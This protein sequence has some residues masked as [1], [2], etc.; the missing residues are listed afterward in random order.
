MEFQTAF[1]PD[2]IARSAFLA[3]GTTVLGDVTVGEQSSI[4]FGSVVR[5]DTEAIRIGAGSNIQDL[6]VLH[7]DPGFPCTIGDG[8]TVGH[9]AIVHGATVEND[10]LIGMRAVV[11]NGAVIG[12]GSLIAAG[13][14]VT[15]GM[16]IP[17]GSIVAGLPAKV[18]G[19]VREKHRSM[20]EHAA[21][22]Y[23]AAAAAHRNS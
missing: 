9:G 18:R 20:I 5:G 13:A 17:P 8:V 1:R 16:S 2:Q 11:L 21:A 4:W 22:H 14:V 7:A 6:S 19:D 15:E 10:V 3:P 23:V 12:R